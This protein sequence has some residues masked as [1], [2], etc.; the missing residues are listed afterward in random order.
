M[1]LMQQHIQTT[2]V[3]LQEKD[4]ESLADKTDGYSG[5]DLAAL[6]LDALFQPVR[7]LQ[8][9]THWRCLSSTRMP[10]SGFESRVFVGPH[11]AR[12]A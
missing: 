4:W 10:M 8:T 2:V 5:S 3:R 9:A 6:T 7:E 1:K 12:G 11:T